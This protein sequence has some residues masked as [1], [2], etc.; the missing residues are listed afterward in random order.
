MFTV[1]EILRCVPTMGC[2]KF[3]TFV[4]VAAAFGAALVA[5]AGTGYGTFEDSG[6]YVNYGAARSTTFYRLLTC[7]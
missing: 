6:V 7:G 5:V 4:V 2:S 3:L 1:F